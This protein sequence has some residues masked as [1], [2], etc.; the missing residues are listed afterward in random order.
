MTEYFRLTSDL[1]HAVESGQ[2]ALA[3]AT[4]VG[5]ISLQVIANFS[6][7]S[8]YYDL[9]NYRQAMDCLRW[10][11]M[12]LVGD[13]IQER[14]GM[15]GLPSVLSR[16]HLSWS[17]AELGA[18]A[19][20]VASGEEGGRIAEAAKHPFSLIWAYAGI[21]HLYLRKGDLLRGIPVLGRGLELC[22]VWHIPSLFPTMA[23][24]V[25]AAYT[26]AGRVAEA[27]PCSLPPGSRRLVWQD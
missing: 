5:D 14:F 9:G 22:Q 17:L 15:T 18:F 25:G 20:G 24:T 12:F 3:L 10:N 2:R 23:S 27:L 13:L 8:V 7:G 26:L 11:V 6:V 16:V 4:A 21:G 19:E 1:D